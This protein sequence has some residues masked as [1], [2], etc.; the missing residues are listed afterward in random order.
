[1]VLEVY[2][3]C[4]SCCAFDRRPA[5]LSNR[6]V[7]STKRGLSVVFDLSPFWYQSMVSSLQTW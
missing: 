6:L 2:Q 7:K 5:G 1:V 4:L 3:C